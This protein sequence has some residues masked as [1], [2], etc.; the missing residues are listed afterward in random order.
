MMTML[1]TEETAAGDGVVFVEVRRGYYRM[2]R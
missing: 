1:Q 2:T